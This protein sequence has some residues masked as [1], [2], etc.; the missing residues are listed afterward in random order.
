MEPIELLFDVCCTNDDDTIRLLD[1]VLKIYQEQMHCV[2]V[3]Q[4]INL[5]PHSLFL[6]FLYR[7]GSTYDI[8]IDLLI[9]SSSDFLTF[10][11]RYIIYACHDINQLYASFDDLLVDL[12]TFQTIVANTLRVLD[13]G[14]F[15][16]NTKPLMKRLLLLEEQL[17]NQ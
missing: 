14:G 1:T 12:D 13:G 4:Q 11:H 9:D 8:L 16:Y 10:F 2:Y 7:C 17:Y 5:N 6:F 3:L 15:P